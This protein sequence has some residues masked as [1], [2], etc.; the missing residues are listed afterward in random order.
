MAV[1]GLEPASS[2]LECQAY[3]RRL[4]TVMIAVTY[5][6][7]T[8]G[9]LYRIITHSDI[10]TWPECTTI[11]VLQCLSLCQKEEPL[12]CQG[13]TSTA[14]ERKSACPQVFLRGASSK[15]G[16][17]ALGL[18]GIGVGGFGVGMSCNSQQAVRAQ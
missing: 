1:S 5:C 11:N 14:G 4:L 10:L 2:C 8:N 3:N 17:R 9:M 15:S 13:R 12:G 6:A 16:F 18:Y 7:L